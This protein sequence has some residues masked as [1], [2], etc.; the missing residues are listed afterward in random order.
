MFVCLCVCVC[1]CL[2]K[3]KRCWPRLLW[4]RIL[5]LNGERSCTGKRLITQH[6]MLVTMA[7][8][9][10]PHQ[11][12]GVEKTEND[13]FAASNK[14]YHNN[15]IKMT[16]RPRN[17][18]DQKRRHARQL[19]PQTMSQIQIRTKQTTHSYLKFQKR[20][21]THKSSPKIARIF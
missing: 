5:E 13:L 3:L 14:K 7:N 15:K 2:L 12:A 9:T 20:F 18:R 10:K 19:E 11:I 16:T 6:I 21:S 17:E 4:I 8:N 1:L